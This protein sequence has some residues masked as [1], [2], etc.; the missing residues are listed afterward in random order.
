MGEASHNMNAVLFVNQPRVKFPIH[1]AILLRPMIRPG[2][3]VILESKDH[4]VTEAGAHEV[5]RTE[6]EAVEWLPIPKE[7]TVWVVEEQGSPPEE[8]WVFGAQ[9]GVTMVDGGR[10]AQAGTGELI[11]II[12]RGVVE[13]MQRQLMFGGGQG[14]SV[15]PLSALGLAG[16]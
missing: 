8:M 9:L 11:G 5:R 6:G 14:A 15:P 7:A 13:G 12:E 1:G 10:V 2:T 16:R 3:M 4:R